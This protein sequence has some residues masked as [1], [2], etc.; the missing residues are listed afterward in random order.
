MTSQHIAASRISTSKP[1]PSRK[2]A[3]Q[4]REAG[5]LGGLGGSIKASVKGRGMDF[6]QAESPDWPF[7][8][9]RK[10]L[11]MHLML[12]EDPYDQLFTEAA[13]FDPIG[14]QP[15]MST[16]KNY[17]KAKY[18]K[19]SRSSRKRIPPAPPSAAPET[20]AIDLAKLLEVENK[21]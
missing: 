2:G 19:A 18:S 11:P 7:P 3:S 8:Q 6:G 20:G 12:Y 14:I 21:T 13:A 16:I 5:E 17:A 10:L 4:G 1:G 15:K 9:E